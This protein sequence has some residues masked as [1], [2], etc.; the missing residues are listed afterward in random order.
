M[1]KT[2]GSIKTTQPLLGSEDFDPSIKY[3]RDDKLFLKRDS[4]TTLLSQCR[5][6]EQELKN[7]MI[8][9][10]NFAQHRTGL[11]QFRFGQLIE[12]LYNI[13]SHPLIPEL[14]WFFD[15][16]NDGAVW[17]ADFVKGLDI[18]ERGDF[19]Q[20]C[21]MVWTV[22]NSIYEGDCLDLISLRELFKRCFS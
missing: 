5:Y 11:D 1:A 7:L 3:G 21:M 12:S 8:V 14:F 22:Y 4:I 2:K 10:V 15:T 18:V 16:D 6:T 19:E 17:F 9:Y 13:A 20:K